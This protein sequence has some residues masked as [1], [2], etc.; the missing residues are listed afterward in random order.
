MAQPGDDER[1][2]AGDVIDERIEILGLLGEG[3]MG[4]VYEARHRIIGR[5]VAV[6]VLHGASSETAARR[7][8]QEA[9]A[10]GKIKHP[11]VV[12]IYDAGVHEGTPYAVMERLVGRSL[13]ERLR[14][15]PLD[16]DEAARVAEGAAAGIKAAHDAG[17]VHRDVKPANI[18]LVERDGGFEVKIL[19]FGIAK[20]TDVETLE[21]RGFQ[22]QTGAIIGT[23]FYM[24]PEQARSADELTPKTD[25]FSLAATIYHAVAGRA[26][27]EGRSYSQ[28][29]LNIIQNDP[30]PLEELLGHPSRL[31]EAVMAGLAKDPG[32]RP[33]IDEFI[34]S[35]RESRTDRH[36]ALSETLPELP[37]PTIVSGRMEAV[38][39]GTDDRSLP[40]VPGSRRKLLA[41]GAALAALAVGAG[42]VLATAEG[43][44]TDAGEPSDAK[45]ANAAEP[46]APADPAKPAEPEVPAERFHRVAVLAVAETPMRLE[47]TPWPLVSRITRELDR[48]NELRPV[49]PLA[50]ME[51]R[52]RATGDDEM[53]PDVST[54]KAIG[55]ALDAEVL[56]GLVVD[57]R[58]DEM[59]VSG[60]IYDV[61]EPDRW[62]GVPAVRAAAD[63]S[64]DGPSKVANSIAAALALHWELP[65]LTSATGV[66][67]AGS[68]FLGYERY[69]AAEAL[70]FIGRYPE[71]EAAAREAVAQNPENPLYRS[72]LACALSY[73]GRNDEA[74]ATVDEVVKLLEDH[75]LVSQRDRDWVSQDQL[76]VRASAEL[77]TEEGRKMAERVV[78]LNL[79]LAHKYH[80][81][82]GYLYAAYAYD[83][84]LT[85]VP[86]ARKLLQEARRRL[87]SLYPAYYGEANMLHK[88]VAYRAEAARLMWTF[89]DCFP[90]SEMHDYAVEDAKTWKLE[91]PAD[92]IRCPDTRM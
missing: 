61:D 86:N 71:C 33:T 54:A 7:F 85:D 32:E 76:W 22:T 90:N 63:L 21:E 8:L 18:F 48:Y 20:P 6:K 84:L 10:V 17:L 23:P 74:N 59:V 28:L 45:L 56:V 91:R 29:L 82:M 60:E 41:A 57:L 34:V 31:A 80:D 72:T 43:R 46:A 30:R 14:E 25:V 5:L 55:A 16:I 53:L 19:D 88:R 77:N 75:P 1:L 64:G 24:S 42:V 26:P 40:P 39:P 50:L 11:N 78:A 58:G 15:G 47:R 87:P 73:Q 49:S 67:S 3:G 89:I 38:M 70:C 69:Y 83:Y 66:T 4:A 36:F 44:R 12:D 2:K 27:F 81:P 92:P 68:F 79:A 62:R 51:H 35:M 13:E 65:E 52:M 9:R 37:P